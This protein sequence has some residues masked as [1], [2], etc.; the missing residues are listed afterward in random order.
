MDLYTSSTAR[1]GAGIQI[2]KKYSV[3]IGT[4][5]DLLNTFQSISISHATFFWWWLEQ[6]ST[7]YYSVL[8]RTTKYEK[9]LQ[10][11]TILL[12]T[13]PY[14]KV[15]L[16]DY[17]VLQS[18]TTKYCKVQPVLVRLIVATHDTSSTLR[19][20]TSGMQNTV[21]LRHSCLIVATQET[22]FTLR[23]A[24]YGM[25]NALEQWHSCLSVTT[26]ET[27]LTLR[28]ATGVTLQ[29]HQTL[30]LP[31]KMTLPDLPIDPC[32]RIKPL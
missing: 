25:Q 22:S 6:R 2:N 5:C 7:K 4:D 23:E 21:E 11:T 15:L 26:H 30:P 14:Y 31:R 17:Y 19:G 12:R 16:R 32:R 8:Q 10:S 24:T 18:R 28:G 20:A 9:V 3:P 1:G 13:T 29:H 27:S